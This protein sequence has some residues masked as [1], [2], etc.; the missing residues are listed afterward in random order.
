MAR[1]G[2]GTAVVWCACG[3]ISLPDGP[4]S[5]SCNGLGTSAIVIGSIEGMSL[6]CSTTPAQCAASSCRQTPT[7]AFSLRQRRH[8]LMV[9]LAL[10]AWPRRP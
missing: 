3:L 8:H 7:T 1:A 5:C 2:E 4:E 10:L 6:P 9:L